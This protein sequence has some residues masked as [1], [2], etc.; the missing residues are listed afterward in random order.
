MPFHSRFLPCS[1]AYICAFALSPWWCSSAGCVKVGYFVEETPARFL[2]YKAAL[3]WEIIIAFWSGSKCFAGT[4]WKLS[5]LAFCFKC[6]LRLVP[7]SFSLVGWDVSEEKGFQCNFSLQHSCSRTVL[8]L[9][10]LID[11]FLFLHGLMEFLLAF[12]YLF[13]IMPAQSRD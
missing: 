2:H 6:E 12:L 8:A 13:K 3:V 1:S 4:A 9:W 11:A 10:E 5:V 7:P